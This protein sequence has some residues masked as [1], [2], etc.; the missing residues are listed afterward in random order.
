MVGVWGLACFVLI[1]SYNCTLTSVFTLPTEVKP[2]INSVYDIPKGNGLKIVVNHGMGAETALLVTSINTYNFNLIVLFLLHVAILIN[3]LKW[4]ATKSSG[5]GVM[6]ELG[7]M[8]RKY[9]ELKCNSTKECLDR[10]DTGRYVYIQ[11]CHTF[12]FSWLHQQTNWTNVFIKTHKYLFF[13][14]VC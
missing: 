2:L 5:D 11:V 3:F 1:Q 9:P 10:V 7:N 13:L 8:L 12:F 14:C 6:K 4:T